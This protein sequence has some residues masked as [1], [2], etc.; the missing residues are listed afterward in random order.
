MN[1]PNAITFSRLIMCIIF[2]IAAC[3]GGVTGSLIAFI[4]FVL[5]SL[6]DFLD[7]YLARRLNLVTSL[8]KLMD[9]LADKILVSSAFIYLTA[10]GWCP[11][12]VTCLI[13]GRE[14]LVTGLRQVA[15]EQGVVIAADQL[16][17]WK[18][19]FQMTYCLAALLGIFLLESSQT[20][21]FLSAQLTQNSW[22]LQATLWGSVLLTSISG[23]NYLRHSLH[24]FR[25]DS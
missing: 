14:F 25:S 3:L 17:K 8:G 9:P 16:G 7:G 23:A 13:I 18:T 15:I 24:L 22:L 19:V 10:E 4:S 20:G 11:V 21:S 1:L 2:V 12:W 6:S 5:A